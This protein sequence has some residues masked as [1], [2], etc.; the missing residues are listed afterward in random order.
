MDIFI[1]MIT[2]HYPGYILDFISIDEIFKLIEE[3]ENEYE[4]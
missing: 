2:C 1:N 3:E 4:N